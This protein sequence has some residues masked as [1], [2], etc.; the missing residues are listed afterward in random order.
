MPQ[1][2]PHAS[3]FLAAQRGEPSAI[4]ELLRLCA[5]DLRRFAMRHCMISQ[6]DDAVQEALLVL[7]RKL[8]QLQQAAALSA[9][10]FRVVQR[11]CR[12]LARDAL[13]M[14]PYEEGRIDA[15]FGQR[16]HAELQWDVAHAL[17]SLPQRYREVVLLRDVE[18]LTVAEIGARLNLTTAATKSLIHRARALTRE[19]L[20]A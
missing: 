17:E 16:P 20:L 10:L 7:A 15:W 14:D 12:R 9:W 19:Y 13:G 11:S 2:L 5:P 8:H 18:G 4:A 1:P 3:L 6:V